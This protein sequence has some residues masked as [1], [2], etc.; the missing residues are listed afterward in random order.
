MYHYIRKIN[1]SKYPEF[2][3]LEI[4][5]FKIQLNYLES[6]FNIIDKTFNYT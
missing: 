1:R 2:K 4:E 5:N 3:G 6:K